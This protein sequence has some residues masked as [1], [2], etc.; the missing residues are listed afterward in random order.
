MHRTPILIKSRHDDLIYCL[1]PGCYS[2]GFRQGLALEEH[3][4]AMHTPLVGTPPSDEGTP[5]PTPVAMD[6]FDRLEMYVQNLRKIADDEK[7]VDEESTKGKVSLRKQI[8]RTR[9][10]GWKWRCAQCSQTVELD[11]YGHACPFCKQN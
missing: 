11:C 9:A 7:V 5:T 4:K 10:I 8:K 6:P 2:H 1:H 3:V